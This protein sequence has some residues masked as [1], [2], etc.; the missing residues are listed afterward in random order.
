MYNDPTALT[1]VM[2]CHGLGGKY[3]FA[4]IFTPNNSKS[5]RRESVYTIQRPDELVYKTDLNVRWWRLHV[6]YPRGG[7]R[8]QCVPAGILEAMRRITL[9]GF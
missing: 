4:H 8:L 2:L 6:G 3:L 7:M 1:A 5:R 9:E